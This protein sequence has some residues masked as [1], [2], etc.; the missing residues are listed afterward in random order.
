MMKYVIA[1]IILFI[2]FLD[3]TPQSYA[4]NIATCISFTNNSINLGDNSYENFHSRIYSINAVNNQYQF[5]KYASERGGSSIAGGAIV[6]GG[7]SL[8]T[9]GVIM[10]ANLHDQK[11]TGFNNG[12]MYA[13]LGG[14]LVFC[15]VWAYL[16]IKIYDR[17]HGY[18]LITNKNGIG[19]AYSF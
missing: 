3:L 13:A 17:H 4:Q 7:L 5:I 15:V 18:S 12:V 1:S 10:L 9:G 6:C 11:S 2:A 8:A 14:T 16:I 19:I